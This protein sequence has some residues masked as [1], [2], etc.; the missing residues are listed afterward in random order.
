MSPDI[1]NTLDPKN[2]TEMCNKLLEI[3]LQN[4]WYQTCQS[5]INRNNGYLL[6]VCVQ[7][8]ALKVS[9]VA[10]S[11]AYS[12]CLSLLESLLKKLSQRLKTTLD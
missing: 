12:D 3:K 4:L 8:A 10:K 1:C 11:L 9:T 7:K 5:S 6:R 2:V